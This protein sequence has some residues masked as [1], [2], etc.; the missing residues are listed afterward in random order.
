MCFNFPS[1]QISELSQDLLGHGYLGSGCRS[2]YIM[3]YYERHFSP[4]QSIGISDL[5][6]VKGAAQSPLINS[7]FQNG[8][9]WCEGRK[10][11]YNGLCRSKQW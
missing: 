11:P 2:V 6:G 4:R 1:W 3:I 9:A 5:L 7:S 10:P 8:A